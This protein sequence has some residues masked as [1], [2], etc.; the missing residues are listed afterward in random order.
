MGQ[1][2]TY[3]EL[4]QKVKALQKS[5]EKLRKSEQRYRRLAEN[6]PDMIY[7]M[8]LPD[9]KYEFVSLAV[10]AIFGHPPEAWYNTPLLIQEILHPDWHAYF[11]QQWE[12][13]LKGVVP[14]F[15]EYQIIHKDKG[16]RWINQRNILVKD[17]NGFPVAIEGVVTDIT[18]RKSAEETL[19]EVLNFN[20]KIISEAPVGVAIFEM[21]SG[22][23]IDAN[24]SLGELFGETKE[25]ILSQSLNELESWQVS[26]LVK[27]ARIALA[28]NSKK[29]FTAQV[30]SFDGEPLFIDCRLA[31]FAFQSKQ[32]LLLTTADVTQ[33]IEA[34][35]KIAAQKNIAE[36]YL[37][38]AGVIFIGLDADGNIILAN[39]KAY[40]VLEC[41]EKD[42][43]GRNWFDTFIPQSNR[44]EVRTAFKK[45]MDGTMEPIGY[46]ENSIIS[47]SGKEK[48]IAWHSTFLTDDNGKKNGLLGSGEDISEKRQLQA[49]LQQA[50]K[51]ESIGNLAGGIAHDFN[52]ILAA[53][54]GFTELAL[55]DAADDSSLVGNLQEVYT[56]AIRARDLVKQILAFARQSDEERKPIRVDTIVREVLKL[57]RSTIPSTIEIQENIESRSFVMG[58]PSQVHQ[59][60]LNLCTNA[61]QAMEKAGGVLGV[62]LT[63]IEHNKTTPL[64][65]SGL[66]QGGYIT[67][68]VSDTGMGIPAAI[69]DSIFEPYFTTKGIGE[70]TGMGLSLA[71]GIVESYG[72]K[73]TVE[74]RE[75][76]GTVF[77]IYLPITQTHAEHQTFEKENLPAGTEKI[78]FVDDEY[79]IAK[80]GSRILER[81]G[82]RVTFHT[83]SLEALELFRSTPNDFDLVITDMTMP[84]MTGD[85]LAMEL[86]A[87]RPDI[88]IILCTG[89][90]KNISD[91]TATQIGIKAFAYKPMA[92]ADLAKTVR[93]VLDESKR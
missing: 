60:F 23:C 48:F 71:H 31:P 85:R 74:S 4:E 91:Q 16:T 59:L 22:R 8:S 19:Q 81:L 42:V 84:N 58:N 75:G 56:A 20:R 24:D 55:Y 26:D 15:Y 90:S 30:T 46:Y 2:P 39:K 70:G 50:Q 1:K 87:Y 72:G 83:N 53:I 80:M 33:Q 57:I 51:L 6:S 34:E 86:I 49:Q 35:K 32:H 37:N 63:E 41:G 5:V 78:L 21:P 17:D 66:K 76:A 3:E 40:D 54:L 77:S 82:Y 69:I 7:R 36:Q 47:K 79:S 64:P 27:N 10:A 28:D 68:T 67:A 9:G 61:A 25:Q 43:L 62:G 14:P 45:V 93:R 29:R 92:K 52:N 13:L 38:L 44:H 73:I 65:V 89:Y 12:Q 88:P 11:E 18:E